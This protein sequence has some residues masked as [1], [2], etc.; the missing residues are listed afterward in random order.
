MPGSSTTSTFSSK[1][2]SYDPSSPPPIHGDFDFGFSDY[3]PSYEEDDDTQ[4]G[5]G[6][7]EDI[8]SSDSPTGSVSSNGTMT[9][10]AN[11]DASQPVIQD[12]SY[13]HAQSASISRHGFWATP[14][15]AEVVD[16]TSNRGTIS[17]SNSRAGATVPSSAGGEDSSAMPT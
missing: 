8:Y 15:V 5:V 2:E 10:A 6:P 1:D 14:S 9:G 17:R 16:P 3:N 12:L 4:S 7:S 11:T 13:R